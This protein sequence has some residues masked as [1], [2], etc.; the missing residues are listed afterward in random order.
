MTDVKKFMTLNSLDINCFLGKGN[1]IMRLIASFGSAAVLLFTSA[2]VS[3]Q[4]DDVHANIVRLLS[5]CNAEE[6][7]C[8]RIYAWELV[9]D[10]KM[11]GGCDFDTFAIAEDFF[12]LSDLPDW[13]ST[14]GE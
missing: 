11:I 10:C 12:D 2:D 5:D 8:N 3:S 7:N 9:E 4:S 13:S 14:V 1:D 6:A